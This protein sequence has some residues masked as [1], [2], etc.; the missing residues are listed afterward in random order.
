LRRRRKKIAFIAITVARSRV[1]EVMHP[2]LMELRAAVSAQN[3]DVTGPWFT[4]HLRAPGESFDF[5]ICLPVAAP[6]APSGRM[7]FREWPGMAVAQTCY[8]GGFEGLG[9][10]WGSFMKQAAAASH[11][12]SEDFWERYLVGPETSPDAAAWRT[13]LNRRLLAS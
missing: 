8:H 13:E 9:A 7:Q 2:G 6:V 5:E 1:R 12:T 10:A 4:H 3:V 11:A